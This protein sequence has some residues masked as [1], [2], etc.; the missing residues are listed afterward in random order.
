MILESFRA[1]RHRLPCPLLAFHDRLPFHQ[2]PRQ[3]LL[4]SPH[5]EHQLDQRSPKLFGTTLGDPAIVF[6]HIR[7][8]H[9]RN[10]P[11]EGGVL[12]ERLETPM[13]SVK[14]RI[15]HA[16]TGP[17][18]GIVLTNSTARSFSVSAESSRSTILT[19]SSSRS[20][21][22]T[23]VGLESVVRSCEG[24]QDF[25]APSLAEDPLESCIP[26][27][28]KS[29][30]IWSFT[31]TMAWTSV[32]VRRFKSRRSCSLASSTDEIREH[33]FFEEFRDRRGVVP[34]G[35]LHRLIDDFELERVDHPHS[36]PSR[37]IRFLKYRVLPVDSTPT[38]TDCPSPCQS[39]TCDKNSWYPSSVVL[40]NIPSPTR[41]NTVNCVL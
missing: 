34:I 16:V 40:P 39:R 15:V 9:P 29:P 28:V 24:V 8:L 25:L 1:V 3:S 23:A 32:S 31:V 7:A 14:A 27:P 12:F 6:G 4:A 21:V 5:P 36:M 2:S 30:C 10:E 37:S 19:F 33:V 41:A 38:R 35:L 11:R 26:R 18:P 20:I 17:Q 22:S 13:S